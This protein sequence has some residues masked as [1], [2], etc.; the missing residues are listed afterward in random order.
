MAMYIS[1]LSQEQMTML[2][3][4]IDTGID[5]YQTHGYIAKSST[6]AISA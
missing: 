2:Y 3:I 5:K 1:H 4:D 6:D